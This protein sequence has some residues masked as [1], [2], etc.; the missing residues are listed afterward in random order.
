MS[1]VRQA[2]VKSQTM[3]GGDA[4]PFHFDKLPSARPVVPLQVEVLNSLLSA[5]RRKKQA[6]LARELEVIMAEAG[7]ATEAR[8]PPSSAG[9]SPT[10]PS[11]ALPE[12]L[13]AD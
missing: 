8:A 7:M 6:Q 10:I 3:A 13:L 1:L 11:I 9:G 2:Y 4:C 12:E 5:M